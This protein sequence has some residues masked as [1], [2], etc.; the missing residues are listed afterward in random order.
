MTAEVLVCKPD[1][2]Q[3]IETRNLPDNWFAPAPE[4]KTEE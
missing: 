2:S 4:E 3:T 1:G